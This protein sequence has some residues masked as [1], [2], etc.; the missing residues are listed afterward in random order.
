MFI[1]A[2]IAREV[3]MTGSQCGFKV[4]FDHSQILFHSLK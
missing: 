3:T 2:K 1:I 4:C